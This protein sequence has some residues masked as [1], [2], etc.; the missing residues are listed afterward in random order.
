MRTN[1]TTEKKLGLS[2]IQNFPPLK[3][4]K[5]FSI[6]TKKNHLLS[7]SL[8]ENSQFDLTINIITSTRTRKTKKLQNPTI[9]YLITQKKF[10]K[11]LKE[12]TP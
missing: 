6:A 2:R 10:Q 1:L 12:T 11:H 5:F 7:T 3:K 8:F 9:S 4:N